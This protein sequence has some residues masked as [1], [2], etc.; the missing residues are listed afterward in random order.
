MFLF[1]KSEIISGIF[2]NLI[3]FDLFLGATGY[4]AARGKMAEMFGWKNK[5]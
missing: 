5:N 4:F 3:D 2:P 1:A